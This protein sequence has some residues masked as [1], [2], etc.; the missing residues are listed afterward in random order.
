M[1]GGIDID[2]MERRLPCNLTEPGNAVT[3]RSSIE[4]SYG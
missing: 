3:L 1:T 4:V 2:G